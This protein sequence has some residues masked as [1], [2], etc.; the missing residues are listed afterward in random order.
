MKRKHDIAAVIAARGGSV[1]IPNKNI[2]KFGDT[3]LLEHKINQLKCLK[4]L[5]GIYVSSDSARILDIADKSGAHPIIRDPEYCTCEVPINEVYQNVVSSVP[6]K[7]IMFVHITSPLIT[8]SSLQKCIDEYKDAILSSNGPYDSLATVTALHKFMW[9]NGKPVNYN[10]DKMPRSQDL[11]NYY[12]LNFAVNIIPK[13]DI[14]DGKNIIGK[15]F[16]P[17]YLD[18]LESFDIDNQVEFEIAEKI[19]MS[20]INR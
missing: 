2:K 20:D 8:T 10:P 6:H 3:N 19:Y 9:N 1:R 14:I 18:E 13:R 17:Y 16:F 5:N 12:V 4:G 11:P 7:H 15:N